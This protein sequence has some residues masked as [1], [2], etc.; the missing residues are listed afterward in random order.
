MDGRSQVYELAQWLYENRENENLSPELR[1]NINAA[2]MGLVAAG[3]SDARLT[4]PDMMHSLRPN[5]KEYWINQEIS[6]NT[7]KE[8]LR[9]VSQGVVYLGDLFKQEYYQSF[10]RSEE[11]V[12]KASPLPAD[13]VIEVIKNIRDTHNTPGNLIWKFVG[14]VNDIVGGLGRFYSDSFSYLLRKYDPGTAAVFDS[15]TG[16]AG[17]GIGAAV[18]TTVEILEKHSPEAVKFVKDS[19]KNLMD[20]YPTENQKWFF[21]FSFGLVICTAT[22]EGVKLIA[23]PLKSPKVKYTSDASAKLKLKELDIEKIDQHG[24]FFKNQLDPLIKDENFQRINLY[25]E[26]FLPP[27]GAGGDVTSSGK[28]VKPSGKATEIGEEI[29]VKKLKALEIKEDKALEIIKQTDIKDVTR[30]LKD[31]EN[32]VPGIELGWPHW[33]EVNK[34][35]ILGR[36]YAHVEG[37]VFSKHGYENIYPGTL[38]KIAGHSSDHPPNSISPKYIR[39]ILESPATVMK[40]GDAIVRGE[41]ILGYRRN[42]IHDNITIIKEYDSDIIVT[43]ILDR[44]K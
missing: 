28:A 36:E 34:L 6:N 19:Y 38:G 16:I 4:F 14:D 31:V 11:I 33:N 32:K 29:S 22:V 41:T 3:E 24:E 20:S 25:R 27:Q 39:W 1:K 23:V 9:L 35:T 44:K 40:P 5:S 37:L 43:V 18:G 2:G 21:E 30:L 12:K 13:Y 17:K 7:L 15:V 26:E 10:E 8:A 42:F